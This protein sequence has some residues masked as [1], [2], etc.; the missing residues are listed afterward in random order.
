MGRFY[1]HRNLPEGKVWDCSDC[2][3]NHS[4][5]EVEKYLRENMGKES[6]CG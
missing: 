2:P 3:T 1:F 5:K 6:N 4:P